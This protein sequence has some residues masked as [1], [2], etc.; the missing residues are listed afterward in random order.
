ML[1]EKEGGFF[2]LNSSVNDHKVNQLTKVCV[3]AADRGL[4]VGVSTDRG[5]VWLGQTSNLLSVLEG[6]R[7][8]FCR[9]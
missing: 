9:K 3:S 5:S 1:Y 2:F 4:G 6:K 8:D 7:E